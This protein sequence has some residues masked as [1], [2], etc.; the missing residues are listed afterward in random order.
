LIH[1]FFKSKINVPKF[2]RNVKEFKVDGDGKALGLGSRKTAQAEAWVMKGTGEIFING[3]PLPTVFANK[4]D[5]LTI[6]RGLAVAQVIDQY[7]VWAI[8]KD[9]GVN[10]QAEAIS[11]AINRAL[12][13]HMPDLLQPFTECKH[14]MVIE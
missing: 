14:F 6:V 9:G 11:L 3:H 2:S 4:H 7:N 8:V 10:C 5:R 1:S 13:S 12:C